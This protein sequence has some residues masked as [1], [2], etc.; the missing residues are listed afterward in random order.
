MEL[1]VYWLGKLQ[2]LEDHPMNPTCLVT[3]ATAVINWIS[4]ET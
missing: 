2:Y 1:L 3:G 4:H